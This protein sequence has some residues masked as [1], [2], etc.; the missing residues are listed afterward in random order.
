MP[1]FFIS[2]GKKG[3]VSWIAEKQR[4]RERERERVHRQSIA[5]RER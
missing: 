4:E 2:N 1:V 3:K 5:A